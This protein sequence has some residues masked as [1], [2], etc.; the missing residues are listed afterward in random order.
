MRELSI[1][2][3]GEEPRPLTLEDCRVAAERTEGTGH[4]L[5]KPFESED[6]SAPELNQ[7]YGHVLATYDMPL[8]RKQ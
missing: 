7:A 3:R 4:P 2:K 8:P 5:H 1:R 6:V